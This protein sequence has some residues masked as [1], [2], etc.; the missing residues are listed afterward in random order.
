VSK[1]N[2]LEKILAAKD[3]LLNT[4]FD[5]VVDAE[6]NLS[7]ME[8]LRK[9][10]LLDFMQSDWSH[11]TLELKTVENT[12]NGLALHLN[13]DV[14]LLKERFVNYMSDAIDLYNELAESKLGN[15]IPVNT[16]D[17]LFNDEFHPDLLEKFDVNNKMKKNFPN[18]ILSMAQSPKK[19]PG[20]DA[21]A[22]RENYKKPDVDKYPQITQQ[23][24]ITMAQQIVKNEFH[25]SIR[26]VM[27]ESHEM[28]TVIENFP[29]WHYEAGYMKDLGLITQ[30]QLDKLFTFKVFD[31]EINSHKEFGEVLKS[32]RKEFEVRAK[33][34][35]YNTNNKHRYF[36]NEKTK[37]E[38]DKYFL[39][40][41]NYTDGPF[42]AMSAN[43]NE[44]V[45]EVK[46]EFES[47]YYDKMITN[48][49]EEYG[50]ESL[51]E[52]SDYVVYGDADYKGDLSR[53][54]GKM[55][56]N[57]I[58]GDYEN[59]KDEVLQSILE[60][61]M[62]EGL[63]DYGRGYSVQVNTAVVDVNGKYSNS[64]AFIDEPKP[65]VDD[66]T[67]YIEDYEDLVQM[68]KDL[69][70]NVVGELPVEQV[71]SM[72]DE[73]V[74]NR[75]NISF[76][77]FHNNYPKELGKISRY[78][79][80]IFNKEV[81]TFDDYFNNFKNGYQLKEGVTPEQF[82]KSLQNF[83][84]QIENETIREGIQEK[85]SKYDTFANGIS[86]TTVKSKILTL[87][88]GDVFGDIIGFN[89]YLYTQEVNEDIATTFL[90]YEEATP[91][92]D[93]YWAEVEDWDLDAEGNPIR[94]ETP[95]TKTYEGQ[96]NRY[97]DLAIEDN[98]NMNNHLDTPAN[99]VDDVVD[100]P[101]QPEVKM[102][103]VQKITLEI[104]D[105][106]GLHA[107]P[108]ARIAEY[109]SKNNI[110]AYIINRKGK[111]SPFSYTEV[112]MKGIKYNETFDIYFPKF[113]PK[114]DFVDNMIL[115]GVGD[116]IDARGSSLRTGT[117]VE[118]FHSEK[119]RD[120]AKQYHTVMGFDE[121]QFK[122]AVVFS[123]EL[124][125]AASDLFEQLPM[126]DEAALPYYKKFI[127]ETNMQ[128]QLLLD[129]GI[130]FEIVDYDPYTPN[131][132]GHNQMI[133]DMENGRLKVLATDIGFGDDTTDIRNPMLA[134]SKYTDVNGR[135]MLENDVFRAVHDTFGHGMRGNTF[136]PI[137]EYN[138][139]L[140]HKEMYSRDA[141][142]VM[143]TETL[144]QN[145]FTN[146]GPHM[147][148]AEGNLIPKGD[149]RYVG[150]ADRPF[151]PQKVAVVPEPLID[152]AGTVV[153]DVAELVDNEAMDKVTQ[154]ANTNPEVSNS[155]L[156]S[157][158]KIVGKAFNVGTGV[159]DPGDVVI[160]QGIGRV[161]PRLGLAAISAPALSAYVFYELSVLAVDAAQ[162]LDKARQNQGIELLDYDNTNPDID[163]KKLGK[164]AWNEFGDLS[165]T[166]SLSWKIS[167]PIINKAFESYGKLDNRLYTSAMENR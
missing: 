29:L 128:Y 150:P 141:Q 147:R 89:E 54:Q 58:L 10:A 84:N 31:L 44:L 163:W 113:A 3:A 22:Q 162:A 56:Y 37:L 131:K 135:V 85:F 77:E 52:L 5:G 18:A 139:W 157:A 48:K 119:V 68:Q 81:I 33:E 47:R 2:T 161:L 53:V 67:S 148:D 101:T 69:D 12:L 164:D 80:K 11:G 66:V 103:D 65:S 51:N 154:L 102:E 86:D 57:Q 158:K 145:T 36:N 32:M 118:S 94:P 9:E 15:D 122:P 83:I 6:S 120:V 91:V 50:F 108:A 153:E 8:Q 45:N 146:Y 30:E 137:G 112:L 97:Y 165:D 71:A 132:A 73:A 96:L 21:A 152:A 159:L 92:E 62:T 130:Q 4:L 151:A 72:Y 61:L 105:P 106:D 110:D 124:G 13:G 136:G 76:E 134:E 59:M 95:D 115:L 138:A 1:Y 156:K 55:V 133:N 27:P 49:L 35:I 125:A 117:D 160:T 123:D 98:Q 14:N 17:N 88:N 143:T 60:P 111:L 129:S 104:T 63:I 39:F 26:H 149:P 109:L 70:K 46:S 40:N 140:A 38:K 99:V 116:E 16:L 43:I 114:Q 90:G 87:V 126:F 144:G 100:V 42:M 93:A 25:N 20:P 24:I 167:E 75:G 78:D 34:F 121:P 7:T 142:R 74:V 107:R 23:D 82:R 41:S 64:V 155:L 19:P 79:N 166:W 127:Q 28:R